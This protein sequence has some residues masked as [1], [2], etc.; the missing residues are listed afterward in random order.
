MVSPITELKLVQYDINNDVEIT[1]KAQVILPDIQLESADRIFRLYV[2]SLHNKAVYRCEESLAFNNTP[3][4]EALDQ[5]RN[6]YKPLENKI[7]N[8]SHFKSSL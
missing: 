8:T 5:I 6:P 3:L 7:D 2:K 4:V 1:D